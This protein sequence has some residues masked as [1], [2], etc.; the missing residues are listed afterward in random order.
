MNGFVKIRRGF[1]EG[2]IESDAVVCEA[3]YEAPITTPTTT[4]PTTTTTDTPGG[5]GTAIQIAPVL[6]LLIHFVFI[7]N[8]FPFNK[9]M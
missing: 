6:L 1:N 5:H 9:I 2:G 7:L 3:D 4:S 8:V